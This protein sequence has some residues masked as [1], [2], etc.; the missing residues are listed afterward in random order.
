[1]AVNEKLVARA[2]ELGVLVCQIP[3]E[4]GEHQG[5]SAQG[6]RTGYTRHRQAGQRGKEICED[7]RAFHAAYV[8]TWLANK[9]N[10]TRDRRVHGKLGDGTEIV[11]YNKAGKWY[12]EKGENRQLV[13][14]D[15]VVKTLLADHDSEH[16]A[17]VTGG[18]SLDKKLER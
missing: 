13:K 17:G 7:C 12:L 15:D 5:E 9:A 18:A 16:Y 14:V 2:A 1:M 4:H 10:A 11:R 8:K 3:I 6:T